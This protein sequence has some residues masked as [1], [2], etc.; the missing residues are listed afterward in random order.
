[1]VPTEVRKPQQGGLIPKEAKIE[2]RARFR[3]HNRFRGLGVLEGLSL[4]LHPI[5]YNLL[6][7]HSIY[8]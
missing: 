5:I 7:D 4:G 2:G 1:M 6:Q 3:G 8:S